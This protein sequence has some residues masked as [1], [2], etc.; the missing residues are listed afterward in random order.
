MIARPSAALGLQTVPSRRVALTT[1]CPFL[2]TTRRR[3]A[4]VDAGTQH[5]RGTSFITLAHPT[6]NV[7][8]QMLLVPRSIA[9]ARQTDY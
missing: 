9:I 7:R 1:R 3:A 2:F 4:I 6:R 5:E 8:P